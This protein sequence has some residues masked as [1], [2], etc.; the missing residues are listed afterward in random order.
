M[1]DLLDWICICLISYTLANLFEYLG[2]FD[3]YEKDWKDRNETT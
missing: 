2:F 3:K 1:I